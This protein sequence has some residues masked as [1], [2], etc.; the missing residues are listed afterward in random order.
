MRTPTDTDRKLFRAHLSAVD[1]EQ[2]MR[3][4]DAPSKTQPSSV[5]WWGLI[6]AAIICADRPA[7]LP[8]R[9]G[10][11]ASPLPVPT[12]RPALAASK[13]SGPACALPRGLQRPCAQHYWQPRTAHLLGITGKY[14][15]RTGQAP[16]VIAAAFQGNSSELLSFVSFR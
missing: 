16:P 12:V 6:L 4:I 8:A 11:I 15:R 14:S 9:G 5:E 1:F 13:E 7:G 3:F 10:G 2:A